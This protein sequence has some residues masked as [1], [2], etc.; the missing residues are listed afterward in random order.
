MLG[1]SWFKKEKP[2][3]GLTGLWG[4]VGSSLIG[5]AAGGFKATGGFLSDYSTPGGDVYRAHIFTANENFE[6]TEIGGPG[7]NLEYII[8][9]AGGGSGA[10]PGGGAGGAGMVRVGTVPIPGVTIGTWTVTIG[11]GGTGAQKG[12]GNTKN[13]NGTPS[14]VAFPTGAVTSIGGGCGGGS[15]SIPGGGGGCAG[16]PAW[17]TDGGA[18]GDGDCPAY[19]PGTTPTIVA[20]TASPPNGWGGSSGNSGPTSGGGG[21]GAGSDGSHFAGPT[22]GGIGGQGFRSTYFYGPTVLK[23]VAAGGGGST[24]GP[25]PGPGGSPTNNAGGGAGTGGPTTPSGPSAFPQPSTGKDANS[26]SGSGAG[27]VSGPT[28]VN[29][30]YGGS[31]IVVIRYKI[32]EL[33]GTTNHSGGYI[34]YIPATDHPKG[35]AMTVHTFLDTGTFVAPTAIPSANMLIL[36]GG[37]GAVSN[38]HSGGGGAGGLKYFEG[39]PLPATTY[40]FVIGDGG[41]MNFSGKDTI[42][43][44]GQPTDIAAAGGAAGDQNAPGDS[45]AGGQNPNAPS[46]T[47]CN[48][49]SH[50]GGVDVVTPTFPGTAFGSNGGNAPGAYSGGG[51]GVHQAGLAPPGAE[52]GK[53]GDGARYSIGGDI[54]YYGGGGGGG[55]HTGSP[56]PQSAGG[57]GGGGAGGYFWNSPTPGTYGGG[58]SAD[59]GRNGGNGLGGGAGGTG[60]YGVTGAPNAGSPPT[61]AGGPT[62][63]PAILGG[64]SAEMARGAKGGSGVIVI[65]YPT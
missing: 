6:V 32:K 33:G 61:E 62:G 42:W 46:P 7:D 17:A 37:G 49:T 24:S 38:N 59:I 4:G 55:G 23:F 11:N 47:T 1:N 14:S 51:G 34:S 16:A 9:G 36:G 40:P 60:K 21:G 15:S 35:T 63:I 52:A 45:S 48:A 28:S 2:L 18:G 19:Q 30:G 54:K 53:G 5:S 31:G 29:G 41:N 43:Y 56:S 12:W 50:P 13:H 8:I 10:G 44:P 26:I 3:L 22:S 25:E 39:R 65:S 20:D 58:E 27:G 64:R 57:A